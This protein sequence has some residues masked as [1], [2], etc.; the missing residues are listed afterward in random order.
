MPWK[1]F[2]LCL[3]MNF[4]LPICLEVLVITFPPYI[5]ADRYMAHRGILHA[6]PFHFIICGFPPGGTHTQ[7]QEPLAARL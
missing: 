7:L 2:T 6:C 4:V 1:L 3:F 5:I